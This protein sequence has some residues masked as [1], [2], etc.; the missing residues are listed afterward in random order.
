MRNCT[1]FE[2]FCGSSKLNL[3]GMRNLRKTNFPQLRT[4]LTPYS[5]GTVVGLYNS[6]LG[7][8][9]FEYRSTH[10]FNDDNQI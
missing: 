7:F 6:D 8:H 3:S 5:N 1:L 10:Y 9:E 2:Q 4:E